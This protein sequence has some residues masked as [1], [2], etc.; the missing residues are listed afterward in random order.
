MNEYATEYS[1]QTTMDLNERRPIRVLYVDYEQRFLR[2]AKR[3]LEKQGRFHVDSASSLED[4]MENLNERMYDAVISDY[5][6]PGKN[7]L[8]FLKAL[9]DKGNDVPFILFTERARQEMVIRALN[10]GAD[11]YVKKSGH[12]ETM[13][14]ELADGVI[15][16]VESRNRATTLKESEEKYKSLVEKSRDSIATSDLKGNILFANKATERLTGYNTKKTRINL[17]KLAAPGYRRKCLAMLRNAKK[18]KQSPCFEFM[19][20]RKDGSLIPIE[21]SCQPIFE[22]GKAVGMQ[23]VTRDISERWKADD[24]LRENERRFRTLFEAAPYAIYSISA[25]DGT[26]TSLNPAFEK[27]TGWEPSEWIGKSFEK[28]VHPDDLPIALE[29][30]Q[31]TI[32][33]EILPPYELR[34]LSKSGECLVGEFMSRPLVENGRIV[35]EFGIV[36]DVTERRRSEESLK[37][38]EEKFRNL[39]E[40]SPNMIFINKNSRVV[41]ANKKAEEAMGYMREEFYSPSF[42]FLNLI[43]PE[44]RESIKSNFAQHTNG[45]EIAPFEYRLV[46]KDGRIIDAILTTKLITYQGDPAILGTI[47]E[48]TDRKK[49][50][51]T[52][53]ESQQKFEGLFMGNPEA[54]AY[55]GPDFHILSVNPRFEELFGYSLAEIRGKHIDEVVVQSDKLEEADLLN[56]KAI[57]GYV[58]HNTLRRRKDGTLVPVSVSAAPITV[59]GSIAGIVAMYNDISVLKKAEKR[60]ETTNEKLQVVGGLTRHD[61]R[62]KLAIITGNVFLAKKNLPDNSDALERLTEIQEACQQIVRIFEFASAYEKLGLEEQSYVDVTKTLE[63]AI[64]LFEDLQNANVT[65]DCHGLTVLADSLLRQFFYNLIDNSLKHGENIT[66]IRIYPEKTHEDTLRLVYEDNGVG[67]AATEKQKLFKEGY[68]TGKGSGHG[69]YMIKKIAEVYG[70]TIEEK[71]KAGSGARFVVTIPARSHNGKENYRIYTNQ[72][73]TAT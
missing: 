52:V 55:L 60:L 2:T 10:L 29:T 30:F 49:A 7:G 65:C 54:A 23:I 69:L 43:A 5:H 47:T 12:Q 38:S 39:A 67:V 44:S 63:E 14:A 45:R 66:Q 24:L 56:G 25:E 18:G 35:G 40:Q 28:L 37:E 34:V 73:E 26:V 11:Q 27:I 53:H 17:R 64:S 6:L 13:Y 72:H 68:T 61:V 19:I 16:A 42:S 58:Y 20:R 9:R 22:N 8:E 32:S 57:D 21:S 62:N 33:G 15:K 48:I 59:E 46:T 3:L 70:W 71:G 51:K 31:K 4:A 36:R 50:E 1:A 41:Y